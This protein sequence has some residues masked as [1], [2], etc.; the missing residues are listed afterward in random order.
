MREIPLTQ[1]KIALVDDED[2]EYLSQFKWQAVRDR[3]LWYAVRRSGYTHIRMHREILGITDP[4]VQVDH[5]NHN[6]LD[7]QRKNL[8]VATRSQNIANT[9]RNRASQAGYIGVRFSPRHKSKPYA[10]YCQHK[11]V[12]MYATAEEA[13]RAYDVRAREVFGEFARLNFSS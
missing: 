8:R 2:Y 4:D 11:F 5:R 12:G 9:R 1:G 6:G 13:A 7:N 3:G 10:V